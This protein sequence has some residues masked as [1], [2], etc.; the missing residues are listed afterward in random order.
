MEAMGAQRHHDM[1]HSHIAAI[2]AQRQGAS[3]FV[4]AAPQWLPQSL[5]RVLY[6]LSKEVAVGTMGGHGIQRQPIGQWRFEWPAIAQC[7]RSEWPG[8]AE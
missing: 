1:Q 2:S 5:A 4:S 8:V 6:P 7:R 3:S